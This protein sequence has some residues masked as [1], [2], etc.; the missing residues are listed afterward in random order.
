MGSNKPIEGIKSENNIVEIGEHFRD[1]FHTLYIVV[2]QD[3][4][5]TATMGIPINGIIGYH[6]FKNYAISITHL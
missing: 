3:I 4:D 5:L 6:F 1:E 2:D